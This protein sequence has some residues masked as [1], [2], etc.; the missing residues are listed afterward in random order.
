MKSVV[1]SLNG[2][3][4]KEIDLPPIFSPFVR[5]DVI[6]KCFIIERSNA[7]QPYGTSKDAGKRHAVNS[8]GTGRGVSRIPRLTGGSKAAFAPQAVGGRRTHPPK[9][10]KVWKRKI[11]KKEKFKAFCSAFAATADINFVSK[12]GH[13]FSENL[14]FPVIV[15]NEFE[16]LERTKDVVE[17][18]MALGVYDDVLRSFNGRKITKRGYRIPK[19]ILI[20]CG[21]N[22]RILQ[23]ARN[24]IGVDIRTLK[25]LKIS[26]IAPGG[27]PGRLTIYSENA[28]KELE[29]WCE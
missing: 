15:E 9:V 5:E 10:E 14:N 6:K 26:D 21:E 11:N 19:S 27:V 4:T 25:E 22:A 23:S 2:E 20:L 28:I 12:R 13:K 29:R 7:R 17:S 3:R 1:Y 8:W 18:L 24:I 16:T